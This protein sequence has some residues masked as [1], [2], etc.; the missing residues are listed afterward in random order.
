MI[1]IPILLLYSIS[2]HPGCNMCVSKPTG[3]AQASFGLLP[4]DRPRSSEKDPSR[5]SST[6]DLTLLP[7]LFLL[8]HLETLLHIPV[9]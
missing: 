8:P 5:P 4:T 9:L 7:L 2:L 6:L 3:P 1:R